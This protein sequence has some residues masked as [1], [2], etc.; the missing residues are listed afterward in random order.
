[1]IIQRTHYLE[2]LV[3]SQ[4]NGLVKIVTGGRRTGKSFLL[5]TL[6]HDYLVEHGVSQEHLIEL[7]LDDRRN[8]ELRNPDA[9]LAYIDKHIKKDGEKSFVILDEIELV[10]DFTEVLLSLMHMKN[11]EV[12]V[13]GSNS[14]FLSKDIATEFRGRGQEIR[15][16]PLTFAEF[17]SA[18][19]TSTAEAWK[20]YYTYGGL[21]QILLFHSEAEKIN[22]LHSIFKVTYLKDIIDRNRIKNTQAIEALVRILA[23]S[24]GS[25]TNPLRI[26]N[27]FKSVAKT[28]LTD[29]TIHEYI[30]NL[31]DAFLIEEAM[32]YDVKGRKYIGTEN[33]YYFSDLGLRNVVLNMRQQEQTH[34]MENVIYNELRS[35]GY[36]V[37]VGAVKTLVS[38]KE[39]KRKRATLEID[40]VVN[41]GAKRI[42]IQSAYKLE[43]AEKTKK[44]KRS[45]KLVGDGFRKLIVVGEDIHRKT[46]ED[47]IV[48]IGLFDFLLDKNCVE[49]LM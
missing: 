48:T 25:S 31:E 19:N 33:K 5:F 7:S 42:Y 39:G 41:S 3:K 43:D 47:G 29:K 11:I 18:A 21:P 20:D 15:L 28:T 22:Y 8:K 4:G 14:R 46:D 37:D 45:L 13:S 32:R 10:D 1:M 17:H 49:T 16:W 35:R 9:L 23:S 44:E 2:M 12:Y 34:I 24:I 26:S 6:F 38:D 30:T 40:F 36:L 27:T